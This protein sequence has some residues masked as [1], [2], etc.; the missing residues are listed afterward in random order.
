MAEIV[1][2]YP[3]TGLDLKGVSVWLPMSVLAVASGVVDSYDTAVIDQRVAADWRGDLRAALGPETLCVGISTMT[4]AQIGHALEAARLVRE[5]CPGLPIVWGGNHPTLL[6]EQTARHPLVDIVV[7]GE[8]ERTFRALV[9]ALRAGRDWR[10]VADI[11]YK[12]GGSV[13]TQGS[14]YSFADP[15]MF[16]ELPYHLINIEHYINSGLG[17]GSATRAKRI[18]PF[19]SSFGCPH[20]CAF[21]CQPVLSGRRWRCMSAAKTAERA[22]HLVERFGLDAVEFFDEEFFADRKRGVEISERIAGRFSFLIQTRMDD[23]LNVDLPSL[24]RSGLVAVQPGIESGS[25]RILELI[26]KHETV[27]QYRRANRTLAGTGIRAT[28][29]FMMGF[30]GETHEDLQQSVDLALEMQ[31][32]YNKL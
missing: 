20:P 19:I 26:R 7:M 8:G 29:N 13:R 31:R 9:D 14:P 2:I 3:I 16:S 11:A 21:C 17:F 5:L 4:G 27:A 18:L 22:S 25:D 10:S 24:E 6:P 23:L 12:S 32:R 1:L 30:P 28:Y 15:E